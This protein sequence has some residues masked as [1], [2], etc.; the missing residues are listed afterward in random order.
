VNKNYHEVWYLRGLLSSL[1]QKYALAAEQFTKLLNFEPYHIKAL[2]NRSWAKG[3]LE[4]Y[5]GAIT[6]LNTCIS[7]DSVYVAAYYARAYWNEAMEKFDNAIH[8]YSKTISLNADYNE[9]YLPLAFVLNKKGEK[10]KACETL[11][12]AMDKGV[13]AAHDFKD[14]YCK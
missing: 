8:D 11:Q 12:K 3:N 4:D 6:D 7:L 9:A 2:Y 5:E 1:K 13:H 10:Q 14:N